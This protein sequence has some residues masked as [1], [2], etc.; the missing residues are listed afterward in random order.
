MSAEIFSHKY[1]STDL[2]YYFFCLERTDL[3][4]ILT[5]GKFFFVVN[6]NK[7]NTL[8]TLRGFLQ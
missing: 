2:I 6:E 3:S 5:Y 4:L 8:L 7:K 1:F